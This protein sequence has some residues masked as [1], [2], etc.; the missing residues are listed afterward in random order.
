MVLQSEHNAKQ[1]GKTRNT[2]TQVV[3]RQ[4][5]NERRRKTNQQS[6][7]TLPRKRPGLSHKLNRLKNDMTFTRFSMTTYRISRII[8]ALKFMLLFNAKEKTQKSIKYWTGNEEDI[9]CGIRAF[10]HI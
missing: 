2:P 8:I 3:T 6:K 10:H 9:I 4:R 5:L 1:N 7:E